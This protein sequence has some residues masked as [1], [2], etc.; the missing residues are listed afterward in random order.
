MADTLLRTFRF[1]VKLRQSSGDGGGAGAAAGA[2]AGFGFSASAS[3][4]ASASVGASASIGA[5]AG[6][7]AGAGVSASASFSASASIGIGAGGGSTL[8]D[9]AFQEC[10]GLEIDLDV[11]EYLEGGRNDGVVRRVGRAKYQNIVLKRG[12]FY[13][14]GEVNADLWKWLQGIASG[15]RPV[16]RYDGTIEVMS[17]G[18]QVVATWTFDRGLPAKVKGPELNAKS[19]ELAIEELHIAHEGLRLTAG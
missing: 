12:M 10:S 7:S 11:Q 2:A 4:G 6:V 1:Q 15:E 3:I 13:G 19:G 17:V 16:R 14:D 5:S 18:D 8:A 9:G